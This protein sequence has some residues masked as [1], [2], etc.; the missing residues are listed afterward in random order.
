MEDVFVDGGSLELFHSVVES[1]R[2]VRDEEA[3]GRNGKA[4]NED[5]SESLEVEQNILLSEGIQNRVLQRSTLVH[6]L[7]AGNYN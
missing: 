4:A 3:E 6:I 1:E 5:G 7:V 2:Q